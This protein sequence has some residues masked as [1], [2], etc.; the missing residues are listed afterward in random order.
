MKFAYLAAIALSAV[1]SS[2]SVLA[3]STNTGGST[4]TGTNVDNLG[5]V[6]IGNLPVVTIA[7]EGGGVI[8]VGTEGSTSTSGSATTLSATALVAAIESAI[9]KIEA[10][11][12]AGA[13]GAVLA[14][15]LLKEAAQ[16]LS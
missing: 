4:N 11:A 3:Q 7:V 2:G 13:V 16:S 9:A 15:S 5:G 14:L 12:G 1:L 6:T 8:T 10:S